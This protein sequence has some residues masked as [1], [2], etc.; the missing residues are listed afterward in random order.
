MIEPQTRLCPNDEEIAARV[1]DGEAIIINLATGSYYS[2]TDAGGLVWASIERRCS[3]EEIAA[4]MTAAYDVSLER[5]RADLLDLSAE[6]VRCG[7][8]TVSAEP[9]AR[10]DAPVAPSSR[11]PYV[12]PVLTAYDDMRNLLAL[13]PP[14]PLLHRAPSGPGNPGN[15]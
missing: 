7:V 11:L 12:T 1:I 14:T 2:M 3:V 10:G 15:R 8:V 9:A 5:A 4:H 13:D 6:L